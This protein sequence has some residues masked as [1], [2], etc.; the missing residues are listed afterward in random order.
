MWNIC[1][2][3]KF[4]VWVNFFQTRIYRSLFLAYEPFARFCYANGVEQIKQVK[5]TP[6]H[7][8]SY[9]EELR[10]LAELKRIALIAEYGCSNE[11][12]YD[13]FRKRN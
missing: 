12:L 4:D 6:N 10:E 11:D 5:V 7:V 2:D 3:H 1:Y 8:G 9:L 13:E